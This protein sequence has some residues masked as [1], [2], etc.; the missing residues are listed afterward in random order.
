MSG[1]PDTVVDE[2]KTPTGGV[3]FVIPP[4]TAFVLV[5]GTPGQTKTYVRSSQP[6]LAI[7]SFMRRAA[8]AVEGTEQYKQTKEAR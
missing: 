2:I 5:A 8:D 1:I 4:D 3:A 7:P 6:L